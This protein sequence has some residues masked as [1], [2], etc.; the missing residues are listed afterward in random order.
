M[1]IA[2]AVGFFEL[3]IGVNAVFEGAQYINRIDAPRIRPDERGRDAVDDEARRRAVH[4]LALGLLPNEFQVFLPKPLRIFAVVE[5]QFF[6]E[7]EPRDLRLFQT[8]QDGKDGCHAER[9]RRQVDTLQIGLAQKFDI[10]LLLLR[11][12]Q[13]V[14]NAHHD[15]PVVERL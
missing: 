15:H 14:G 12:R 2:L 6:H 3:G 7:R 9:I 1:V 13:I 5:L 10:D 11:H 4:A 8:R